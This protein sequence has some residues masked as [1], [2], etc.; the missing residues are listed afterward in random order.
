LTPSDFKAVAAQNPGEDAG[1]L[2]EAGAEGKTQLP[3]AAAPG[4]FHNFLHP[5]QAAISVAFDFGRN[6]GG[7]PVLLAVAGEA[8]LR[9][10]AQTGTVLRRGGEISAAAWLGCTGV[11]G[12]GQVVVHV[13][14]LLS[15]GNAEKSFGNPAGRWAPL[16]NFELE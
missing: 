2:R 11:T 7:A 12:S 10:D 9:R 3:V 8:L 16:T 4:V 13:V 14:A 6:T 5:G 1:L 15:V